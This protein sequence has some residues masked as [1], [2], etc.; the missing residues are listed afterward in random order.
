MTRTR[1]SLMAVAALA[2]TALPGHGEAAEA[3]A[4]AQS[5]PSSSGPALTPALRAEVIDGVLQRLN[6]SYV[7]PEIATQMEKAIRERVQKKEYD[8]ITE[9]AA[10]AEALTTHLQ[11][12]SKDK[13]LRVVYSPTPRPPAPAGQ[14]DSPEERSRHQRIQALRNFGFE[15][16][17]R[18]P[19]NIGYLEVRG[20]FDPA[21]AGE[22]A[23]AAMTFL[24]DTDALII[25][26]RRNGGGLPEMVAVLCSYLF[27]SEPVH[28]NSLYWR[29]QDTTQQF[30]TLPYVPGRR[31]VG[32]DVYV[33]TS[34]RTFS[35]AEEFAYNLKNLKR[36]TLIGETTGGGAHPGGLGM[37][38]PILRSTCPRAAPS[39][40]SP[41]PTGR[42][43]GSRPIR[44]RPP[45]PPWRPPISLR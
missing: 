20:F 5:P 30:W 34:K 15:K 44:K 22:K 36:A 13:H 8:R 18:L 14:Q 37:S 24:A 23:A 17:E 27:D 32:K 31:Y 21:Q 2:A 33:L 43:P 38:L 19:G 11:A 41:R 4:Y 26:L 29:P 42:E 28:L 12:V 25:D 6:D 3:K 7:F 1:V 39:A 40:P 9:G 45:T 10:F 16:I 35:G